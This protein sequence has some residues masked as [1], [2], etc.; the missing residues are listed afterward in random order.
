MRIFVTAAATL[1]IVAGLSAA[2]FAEPNGSRAQ[3][4][5][6]GQVASN[7]DVLFHY[8]PNG[9]CLDVLVRGTTLRHAP[10]A[11]PFASS[12]ISFPAN[13][14]AGAVYAQLF[15]V[16]LA[17]A[18]VSPRETLNGNPLTRIACGPVTPSP[19]WAE[20]AAFAYRANVLGLI[21]SGVNT[22]DG[23]HD[24]GAF[25][26]S[27]ESEGATLVIAY[28]TSGIDKEI[29]VT[30]GNDPIGAAIGQADL[31]LPVASP[32]GLGAELYLIGADGQSPP[33]TWGDEAYWN[34][35]ALDSG[36]AW[37]GLDPGAG[38]GM[39]DSMEF[40]VFTAAP[41]TASTQSQG[42][43]L[44]WVSTVLAVKARGCETVPVE[45]KTWG[46]MKEI[47]RR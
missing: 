14:V 42:D 4:D 34:G 13:V 40:G 7:Q 32:D 41:N 19:C 10:S 29:I 20:A 12:T 33:P 6:S 39:W 46:G 36:D 25:N 26:V 15:W 31:A 2:S 3:G 45:P 18:E 11:P 22:L 38:V 5:N 8:V 35:V 47:Y 1:L 17:D 27:P 37:Q 24:S 16:I 44:N 43:C 30:C 21:Q 23:F 28:R 9:E